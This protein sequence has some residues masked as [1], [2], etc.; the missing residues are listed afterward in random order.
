MDIPEETK[1]KLLNIFIG[2]KV[3]RDFIRNGNKEINFFK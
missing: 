2:S 1:K 3:V